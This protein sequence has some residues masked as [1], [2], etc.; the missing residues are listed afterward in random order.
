MIESGPQKPFA[1]LEKV[2]LHSEQ[3]GKYVDLYELKGDPNWVVKEQKDKVA[4]PTEYFERELEETRRSLDLTRTHLGG[5]LPE[6]MLVVREAD[7]EKNKYKNPR[8]IYFV[9][10][11]IDGKSVYESD[12]AIVRDHIAELDRAL[13]GMVRAYM[14]SW[15]LKE[16][17]T[18]K[19]GIML[20]VHLK[21]LL[22][23]RKRSAEKETEEQ[24]W[25][26]DVFPVMELQCG[27]FLATLADRIAGLADKGIDVTG[28]EFEKF[29]K[30]RKDLDVLCGRETEGMR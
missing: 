28:P 1:D 6:T 4:W 9:Q 16:G 20:D 27:T 3:E 26:V 17:N 21:N 8:K 25:F 30:A 7:A 14:D 15:S 19:T 23:G 12:D 29:H 18:R 5:A 11:R 24:V 13:A 10:E 2:P 22:I